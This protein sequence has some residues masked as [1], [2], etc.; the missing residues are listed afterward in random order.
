MASFN[1]TVFLDAS[2]GSCSMIFEFCCNPTLL[3]ETLCRPVQV[4]RRGGRPLSSLPLPASIPAPPPSLLPPPAPPYFWPHSIHCTFSING[5]HTPH[6]SPSAEHLRYQRPLD[7]TALWFTDEPDPSHL[8]VFARLLDK[9]SPGHPCRSK[10]SFLLSRLLS[11]NPSGV[12]GTASN[13]LSLVGG[14]GTPSSTFRPRERLNNPRTASSYAHTPSHAHSL[15]FASALARAL[16]FTLFSSCLSVEAG[17]DVL[18]ACFETSSSAAA[19]AATILHLVRLQSK[20]L[21]SLR[22]A[23]TPPVLQPRVITG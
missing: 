2:A 21:A 3:V 7:L 16:L 9:A 22:D 5:H 10:I 6:I 19:P 20:G 4:H 14:S 17:S 1:V 11:A 12:A 23:S 15:S 18:P 13:S 8:V